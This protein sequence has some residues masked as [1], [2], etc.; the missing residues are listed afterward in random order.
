MSRLL[1]TL[2]LIALLALSS[3][4]TAQETQETQEDTASEDDGAQAEQSSDA[5][6]DGPLSLGTEVGDQPGSSYVAQ[7][8]DDWQLQCIRVDDGDEPCHLYQLLEDQDGNAVAEVSVFRLPEGG[9]AVAGAT[10]IVPLETLLPAQLTISVDGS[11]GKRYPYSFCN[12][13][14]C[15]ARIGLTGQDVTSFQR[16]IEAT[17]TVVPFAA[18]DQ[19]VNLT[20]SLAGFTAGYEE[21]SVIEN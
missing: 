14:G 5:Q 16:G 13:V 2:P 12:Q 4:L 6:D 20:M 7:E 1:S 10:V 11:Q 15:Y 9:Q 18:P 3:P 19:E 21:T 8:F 17:L